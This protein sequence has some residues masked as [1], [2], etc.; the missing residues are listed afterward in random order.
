MSTFFRSSRYSRTNQTLSPSNN[1]KINSTKT[2]SSSSKSINKICLV[3][4]QKISNS[5][6]NRC[7]K[8][9]RISKECSKSKTM[10]NSKCI[11]INTRMCQLHLM[12]LKIIKCISRSSKLMSSSKT[13]LM[14]LSSNSSLSNRTSQ[15]LLQ[16]TS[17]H[18]SSLNPN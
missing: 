14:T 2:N 6:S 10:F 1:S 11:Q 15:L 7:S 8:W 9:T 3:M 5:S 13:M 16:S 4:L 12:Q 18:H 17:R